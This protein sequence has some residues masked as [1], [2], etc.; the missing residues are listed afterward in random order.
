MLALEGHLEEQEIANLEQ[1]SEQLSDQDSG[2]RAVRGAQENPNTNVASTRKR[3]IP[4]VAR[5]TYLTEASSL[6]SL[7]AFPLSFSFRPMICT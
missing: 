1:P 3:G 5:D 2:Q 7:S 6:I 4:I